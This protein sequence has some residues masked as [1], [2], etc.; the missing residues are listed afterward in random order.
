MLGRYVADHPGDTRHW[1]A[2]GNMTRVSAGLG[3]VMKRRVE[4]I[5]VRSLLAVVVVF[6]LGAG[7]PEVA[8]AESPSVTTS[9]ATTTVTYSYTGEAQVFTVPTGVTSL[10]ITATGAQG[11]GGGQGPGEYRIGAYQGEGATASDVVSVVPGTVYTV[12]VGGAAANAQG[13]YNGGGSGSVGSGGGGGGASDVCLMP[14]HTVASPADCLIVAGGGGGAGGNGEEVIGGF[15]GGDQRAGGA[16]EGQG[17]DGGQPGTASAG[18]AGGLGAQPG[19]DG[20]AGQLGIGGAGGDGLGGRGGGGG[21]GL[22]GGGGGGAGETVGG[23]GGGGGGSSYAPGGSVHSAGLA[24][25]ESPTVTIS[26]P[27][28]PEASIE[29]PAGGGTYLQGAAVTT[30]FSCT[31]GKDGPGIESCTDSNGAS[32]TSGVLETSTLGSHTYTVTARSTDGQTSTASIS[33]TVVKAIC[34]GNTG[35]VTLKPGLTDAAAV[36]TLKIKG[37]LSGCTG[38][39]FTE[40]SYKATLTTANAVSCSVLSGASEM[41]SGPARFKWTPKA[42]PSTV[43]GPLN[44][45][46]SETPS[47]WFH[48]EITA[49]LFSPLTLSGIASETYEGGAKCGV[50]EGKKKAKA[51]KKGTFTGSSVRFF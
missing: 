27:P 36:Q 29:S 14:L 1:G 24:P 43:T 50:A 13:G 46:L 28:A 37:T 5:D 3:V 15:G 6:V 49:G 38:E 26:Y 42:K 11:G 16:G 33:Y 34:T 39:L 4:G 40:V 7:L 12:E 45:V 9:G 35:M 31:E 2:A 48:G 44:L 17:G 32:G 19:G 22:Y 30:R 51:V 25:A 10:Q 41:A 8:M 18:G 21:G 20:S 23:G 47:G